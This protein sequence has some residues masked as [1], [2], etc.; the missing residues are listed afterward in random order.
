M[1]LVVQYASELLTAVGLFIGAILLTRFTWNR[2]KNLPPEEKHFGRPLWVATISIFFLALTSTIN[3]GFGGGISELEV[4]WYLAAILGS[5]LL[6][7]SALMI[8]GSRKLYALPV[9]LMAVIAVIAYVETIIGAGSILGGF[10]DY[11]INVFAVIL[12]GIPFAVF[13]YLRYNKRSVT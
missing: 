4:Y 8:M 3:F 1:Q 5:G 11:A 9:A 12:F 10:T 2:V 6:M 7:I 13:A